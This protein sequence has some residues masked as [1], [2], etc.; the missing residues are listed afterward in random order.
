MDPLCKENSSSN[1]MLTGDP[2]GK[3]RRSKRRKS[4][5][6][7]SSVKEDENV[8]VE[9]SKESNVVDSSGFERRKSL[10]IRK[11]KDRRSMISSR[12]RE[13]LDKAAE[14]GKER[15]RSM[16]GSS[17]TTVERTAAVAFTKRE[18][19]DEQKANE[20]LRRRVHNKNIECETLKSQLKMANDTVGKKDSEIAGLKEEVTKL[21]KENKSLQSQ[22][23]SL[24]RKYEPSRRL[25]A[26]YE[27]RLSTTL[28]PMAAA[29]KRTKSQDEAEH[30][31]NKVSE[32]APKEK[33]S[34]SSSSSSSSSASSR[35]CK[36]RA[37]KGSSQKSAQLKTLAICGFP[38]EK[39]TAY[40]VSAMCDANGYKGVSKYFIATNPAK[41]QSLACIKFSSHALA[42]VARVD[43]ER[44][45]Y[46]V[47]YF[48]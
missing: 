34:S 7:L 13:A 28:T 18:K 19:T 12:T 37:E 47:L 45:G 24:K 35:I 42:E 11:P 3:L 31:L 14:R 5:S 26:K 16:G 32:E 10:R 27:R 48:P 8:V 46:E 17:S 4:L 36:P 38:E 41:A 2:N 25:S 22:V 39:L 20:S 40:H 21:T 23:R 1:V 9:E 6:L 29:R 33:K 30:A 44:R 43:L 15:R